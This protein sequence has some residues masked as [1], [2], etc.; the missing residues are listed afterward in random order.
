MR[1]PVI[2]IGMHR[3]GT[4]ML[5]RLLEEL[6]MFFGTRKD[7]NNEALFFQ[8]LNDWL[9]TQCGGRWDNPG[10]FKDFFWHSD[11]AV[12]WT[13]TYLRNMLA[14]PRAIQF[15]GARRLLSGGIANLDEPWG[16]KDPRTTFTLGMWLKLF[17]DAKV[18]S[19]ERNGVDVAQSL[20]TREIKILGDAQQYYERYRALFFVRPRRAGFASS[21][22]CLSLENAFSLWQEY[23]AAADIAIAALPRERTL[24]LRYEEVLSDPV[25]WLTEA[26]AF[27]ELNAS[28]SRIEEAVKSIRADRAQAYESDTE[29]K[30]FAEAHAEALAARGYST[31]TASI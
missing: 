7:E 3:S 1:T 18:V 19:I 26:A 4:S 20:R 25:R 29:L 8:E 15:L 6:G 10:P 14:S 13:E 16:W 11:E 24:T 5:G 23:T 12:R 28:S 30:R 2:F 17:P 22:R 27:C 21:P 9:L 31:S